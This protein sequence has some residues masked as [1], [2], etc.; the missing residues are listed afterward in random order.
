M[1]TAYAVATDLAGYGVKSSEVF[2]QLSTQ[3]LQNAVDAAN[4]IADSYLA[5]RFK[6][7][8][9]SWGSDLK[10]KVVA[11]A[12]FELLVQR[13]F[14]PAGDAAAAI[15]ESKNDAIRWFEGISGGTVNPVVVDASPGGK[16]G[17]PFVDQSQADPQNPGQFVRRSPA[18]GRGW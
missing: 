6:L 8:L 15:V 16:V 11:I 10:Q 7:P 12:R 17:G 9:S 2:G 4:A 18:A 13:G 14:A 1:A 3:Q 5:A